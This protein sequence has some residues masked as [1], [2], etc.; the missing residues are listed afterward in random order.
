MRL[1]GFGRILVLGGKKILEAPLAEGGT[2]KESTAG[3]EAANAME[4]A[5][6][7]LHRDRFMMSICNCSWSISYASSSSQCHDQE[8]DFLT[9][10]LPAYSWLQLK[11]LQ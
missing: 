7:G 10:F 9:S 11:S 5:V 8:K 3:V 1:F 2:K 4:M 6:A